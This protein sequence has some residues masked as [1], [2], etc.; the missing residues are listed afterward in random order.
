[1]PTT[2]QQN[3]AGGRRNGPQRPQPGGTVH[4]SSAGAMGT[5]RD[6]MSEYVSRG[7]EQMREMTRGHEGTA[8]LVALGAGLGIGLLIGCSLASSQS[9]PKRWSD[10]VMAEGIGR[11]LLERVESIIPEALSERFSK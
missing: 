3:K 6:E 5:M 7:A 8:V 11:R 10:R 1:M 9:R 2:N 4:E